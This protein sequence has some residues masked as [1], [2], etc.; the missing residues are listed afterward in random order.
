MLD[1]VGNPEDRF[2]HNEAQITIDFQP[3]LDDGR[4]TVNLL[5][6]LQERLVQSEQG[7]VVLGTTT[8]SNTGTHDNDY[9]VKILN[10]QTPK[11][12]L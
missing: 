12:L 3:G 6:N 2:S 11:L 4:Q 10:Y 9:T 8:T 7:P 5:A 1:Q